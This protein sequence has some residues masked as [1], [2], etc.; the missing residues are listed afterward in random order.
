MSVFVFS[1]LCHLPPELA[2][3]SMQPVFAAQFVLDIYYTPCNS[4]CSR[5]RQNGQQT[6]YESID[7]GERERAEDEEELRTESSVEKFL[8]KTRRIFSVILDNKGAKLFAVLLQ[9]CGMVSL[10]VLLIVVGSKTNSKNFYL[11]PVVALPLSVLTLAVI[12]S[13]KFQELLL[14]PQRES[15]ELRERGCGVTSNA[16]YKASKYY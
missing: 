12:W 8:T 15:Q 7:L 3:L 1:V 6:D 5:Q 11:V 14:V 4:R 2:I 13:N 10:L 9:L 16:R